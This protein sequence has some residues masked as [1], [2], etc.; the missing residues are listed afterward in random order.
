[1]MLMGATYLRLN[2]R[3]GNVRTPILPLF[4][5]VS[6]SRERSNNHPAKNEINIP[7]SG[8]RI[9][10]EVKSKNEKK[11][12]EQSP[13]KLLSLKYP[14]DNALSTPPM[15]AIHRLSVEALV[16]DIFFSSLRNAIDTSLIE[17]VEVSDAKNNRKKNRIDHN[18]PPGIWAKIEGRTSNTRAGPCTGDMPNENTAGKM[19]IPDSCAT[20][21]ASVF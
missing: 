9:F 8:R 7:P 14:N 21:D 10:D 4:V 20:H 18:C 19:I 2:T 12:S 5:S 3:R 16:R 11:S 1:M 6:L 13:N 17:I 15:S